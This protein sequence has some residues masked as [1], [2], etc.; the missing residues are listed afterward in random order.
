[1]TS[2]GI[3]LATWV[4]RIDRALIL[5]A[6]ALVLV[7]AAWVPLVVVLV[8][9]N[10]TA[11]GLASASPLL[12]IGVL[13]NEMAGASDTIWPLRVGWAQFWI[14]AM[15]IIALALLGMTLATFDRCMGRMT[16]VARPSDRH[17]ARRTVL[18]Q[19]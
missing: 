10:N 1:V 14:L 19:A 2:L 11:L 6:T 5:S 7:T 3:A 12:G 8:G 4:S 13:T 18:L 17:R 15:S 9:E 16:P